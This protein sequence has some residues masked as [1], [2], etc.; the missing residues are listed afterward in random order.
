M[1]HQHIMCLAVI[2]TGV[3]DWVSYLQLVRSCYPACLEVITSECLLCHSSDSNFFPSYTVITVS[4][5]RCTVDE[6][7]S[8]HS[9]RDR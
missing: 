5:V 9:H 2:S 4:A 8:D 7:Y 3:E 1:S 6:P